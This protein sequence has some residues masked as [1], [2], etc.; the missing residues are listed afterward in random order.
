MVS[1]ICWNCHFFVADDPL[2]ALTGVCRRHAPRGVDFQAFGI[3][4]QKSMR[5]DMGL[6]D[7]SGTLYEEAVVPL[8]AQGGVPT[9]LDSCPADNLSGID[10]NILNPSVVTLDAYSPVGILVAASRMNSGAGTVGTNP[11]LHLQSVSVYG[12]HCLNGWSVDIP[13]TPANVSPKDT[14]TDIFVKEYLEVSENGF[15][16]LLGLRVDLTGATENDIAQV[17]NLKVGVVFARRVGNIG[18]TPPTSKAKWANIADG[19]ADFCGE[20]KNSTETIPAI[21]V[22]E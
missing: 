1:K 5:I 17:R 18:L 6:C 22:I 2:T 13:I 3:A 8:K 15:T 10:S 12:D 4:E 20:F 7:G 14:A 11:V 19:S 21:P 9:G 16:G